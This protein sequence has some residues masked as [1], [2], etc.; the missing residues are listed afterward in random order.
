MPNVARNLTKKFN[1]TEMTRPRGLKLDQMFAAFERSRRA[2][3]YGAYKPNRDTSIASYRK[4]LEPFFKHLIALGHERWNDVPQDT[5]RKFIDTLQAGVLAQ[6]SKSHILR[7]LKALSNWIELAPE[8]E[9][10]QMIGFKKLIPRIPRSQ[11]KIWIPEPEVMSKFWNGYTQEM[12]WDFRDYVIV[13]IMLDCGPRGCEIRH[14]TPDHLKLESDSL[15]IPEEGKTGMR[16]VHIHPDTTTLIDK[17]MTTRSQFANSD[18]VFINRF[19][20]Q[21]K[22]SALFQSFARNRERTGITEDLTPH[23]VRHFFATHYLVN[24]GGL[25]TLKTIIGHTSYDT[26]NI[27]L[28]LASQ[29]GHVKK[30][31]LSASPM[32]K[33]RGT[34]FGPGKIKKKRNVL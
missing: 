30:E 9:A 4:D 7:S 19:G 25:A 26:L 33:L 29:I 23:T 24:G 15:L 27:Y 32:A 17:W 11:E 8:C 6:N 13:A 34:V 31:H 21:M 12:L 14:M 1:I 5:T 3:N 16:L 20:G 28:H 18:Y 22:E 2:G 10:E